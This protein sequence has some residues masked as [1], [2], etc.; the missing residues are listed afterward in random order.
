MMPVLKRDLEEFLSILVQININNQQACL[1]QPGITNSVLAAHARA[2]CPVWKVTID[3]PWLRSSP[4]PT[5]HS[6]LLFHLVSLVFVP[7]THNQILL[8]LH[9]WYK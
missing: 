6:L 1:D 9:P 4:G 8:R 5:S 3:K 7:W 2:A